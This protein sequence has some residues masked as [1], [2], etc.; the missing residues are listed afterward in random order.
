M[1]AAM[2]VCSKPSPVNQTDD[3]SKVDDN[4]VGSEFSSPFGLDSDTSSDNDADIYDLPVNYPAS[5]DLYPTKYVMCFFVSTEA[6]I[7][8]WA[9]NDHI[10]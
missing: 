6:P 2:S 5:A 10:S 4:S 9:P 7:V 8:Q 3:D 1:M